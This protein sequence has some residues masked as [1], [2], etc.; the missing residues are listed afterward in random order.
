MTEAGDEHAVVIPFN[1]KKMPQRMMRADERMSYETSDNELDSG[2]ESFIAPEDSEI[3]IRSDGESDGS[4]RPPNPTNV[5]AHS[6][7]TSCSDETSES[8]AASDDESIHEPSP[9]VWHSND[10]A[11]SITSTAAPLPPLPPLP[12]PVSFPSRYPKR[13]RRAAQDV[14]LLHNSRRVRRVL[15]QDALVDMVQEANAWNG[16]SVTR[17]AARSTASSLPAH[18]LRS[19]H[20]RLASNNGVPDVEHCS[21]VDDTDEDAETDSD[22]DESDS[23][24]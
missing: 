13:E 19:I 4:Y 5:D 11:T 16:R 21:D 18:M 12:A 17:S 10:N 14:Y 15:E 9:L 3:S 22:I 23:V 6:Q 7:T 20:S 24:S 1:K 2:D 8:E